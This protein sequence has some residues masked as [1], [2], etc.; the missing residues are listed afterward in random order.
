MHK[1]VLG[2]LG[3]VGPLA[4]AY[5]M[6]LLVRKTPARKD[7]DHLPT[8]V[9]S[10]PQIPDRT[11]HIL[12]GTK[13]NPLPAMVEVA[14]RLEAAGADFLAIPCNTA[15][16]YYEGIARSVN[17][18][19][20]NI[21]EET[22]AALAKG[23]VPLRTVGLMATE[24]TVRSGVFESCFRAHGVEVRVPDRAGQQA[25]NRLIYDQVKAN[26]PFDVEAFRDV[27][28]TLVGSGCDA[29][30]VGCTELSVVFQS[31]D[32]RPVYLYDSL[33]VLASRCVELYLEARRLGDLSVLDRR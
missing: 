15:H 29:V 20:L 17:V 23:V 16:F 32:E 27:A 33:D 28:R 31:L 30:V 10:D 8:I 25:V 21:M 3:G 12:D 4:T 13:P 2:V 11:A 18:P 22:A 6:Q 1:P 5:F 7:Q 14:R 9:F 19:V 24:G 26:F